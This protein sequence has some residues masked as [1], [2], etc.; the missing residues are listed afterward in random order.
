MKRTTFNPTYPSGFLYTRRLCVY[1]GH[2]YKVRTLHGHWTL[3]REQ[4]WMFRTKTNRGQECPKLVIVQTWRKKCVP[5]FL[6]AAVILVY[7]AM[8]PCRDWLCCYMAEFF[9]PY[10]C[11]YRVL[12]ATKA[13]YCVEE[14]FF[15]LSVSKCENGQS[16]RWA[17]ILALILD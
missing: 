8:G 12:E 3:E 6:W 17:T 1:I 11:K 9:V 14:W 2:T 5:I 10:L 7:L 15:Y 4:W 13:D 16:S